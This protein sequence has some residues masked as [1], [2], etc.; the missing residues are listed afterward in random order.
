MSQRLDII[1]RNRGN[2]NDFVFHPALYCTNGHEIV[3]RDMGTRAANRYHCHC[4]K[5]TEEPKKYLS[6]RILLERAPEDY[7]Q[8][9]R[10]AP[11][12]KPKPPRRALAPALGTIEEIR[13]AL[14]TSPPPRAAVSRHDKN[15]TGYTDH[16]RK[17][18]AK[19]H[20][21]IRNA[22]IVWIENEKAYVAESPAFPDLLGIGR[23]MTAALADLRATIEE[24][25]RA[26]RL[27]QAATEAAPTTG[28][29]RIVTDTPVFH[30]TSRI[31]LYWDRA[32]LQY[33]AHAKDWADCR[34]E[35]SNPIEALAA[36]LNEAGEALHR[37]TTTAGAKLPPPRKRSPE[38]EKGIHESY[39][40][41]FTT[42]HPNA[43]GT[44][45]V[46]PPR[47]RARKP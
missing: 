44:I 7:Y 32:K 30:F 47:K 40:Y 12:Q 8:T 16:P 37:A 34:G 1:P 41:A 42:S 6:K 25:D 38:E 18:A 36:L 11:A 45:T 43:S 21:L 9:N 17:P 31:A 4:K 35:G 2:A 39:A 20:A 33:I 15:G 22:S 27:A 29:L 46:R 5:C 26:G 24:A 23:T 14:F 28:R 13:R 19:P 10:G 3:V